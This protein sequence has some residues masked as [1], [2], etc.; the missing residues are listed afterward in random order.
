MSTA[1]HAIPFDLEQQRMKDARH[2]NQPEKTRDPYW[3][4]CRLREVEE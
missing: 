1:V 4:R 3:Y 2:A